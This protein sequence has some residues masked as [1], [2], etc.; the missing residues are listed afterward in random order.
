MQVKVLGPVSAEHAGREISLG[1]RKQRA[2]F[3]LLALQVNRSVPLDRLVHEVWRDEPPAQATLSLQSYISRLRRTILDA[4]GD[5]PTA[6]I[7]RI[8]TRPPGWLLEMAPENID[9]IRFVELVHEGA[10]MLTAGQAE[11]GIANLRGGLAL[12]TGEAFSDLDEMPFAQAEKTRL[13]ELRITATE[14][15]LGGELALGRDAQVV[16]IAREVVAEE[17]YRERA[18]CAWMIALYRQGRQ[19]DALAVAAKLRDTLADGLGLDPSPETR[20]LQEQILRQDPA[21][22]RAPLLSEVQVAAPPLS[23]N[24]GWGGVAESGPGEIIVG[25]DHADTV[26]ADVAAGNDRGRGRLLVVNGPAGIGKSSILAALARRLRHAGLL[27]LEG[28][29]IGAGATPALWPWVSILRQLVAAEPELAGSTRTEGSALALSLLDPS[30]GTGP[31]SDAR[32]GDTDPDLARTRLYRAVVDLLAT[33]HRT[34]PLAV[35]IDDAHWLDADTLELLALAAD[36]LVP[37]GMVVA[38]ALRDDEATAA[39]ATVGAMAARLRSEAVRVPLSGLRPED[40]ELLVQQVAPDADPDER[41][42][43]A[44]ALV[45]RTGGNPLFLSELLRLLHS[46]R[47]LDVSSVE[48][49]LPHQ[50]RDVLRRRL[51]RLPERTQTLLT[52]VALLNRPADVRLLAEVS[53]LTLEGVLDDTEA[54]V[55]TSLLVEDATTRRFTLS[56]DLVRQTLEESLTGLRRARVHA[57]IAEVLRSQE[58]SG[59]TVLPETVVEIAR[60]L[61]LAETVVGASE[62]I[63]YLIRVADDA[64]GHSAFHLSERALRTAVDLCTRIDDPGRRVA[65]QFEL[66]VRFAMQS[67]DVSGATGTPILPTAAEL[68]AMSLHAG[69]DP[70]AWWGAQVVHVRSGMA[71]RALRDAETALTDPLD[72]DVAAMVH[73]IKGLAHFILGDFASADVH[74]ALAEELAVRASADRRE[75]PAPWLSS[76]PSSCGAF[77]S[78]S[79]LLVGDTEAASGH[80]QRATASGHEVPE[81]VF[82]MYMRAWNGAIV[83]D[84]VGALSAALDAE[85][86]GSELEDSYYIAMARI[87]R[88]WAEALLGDSDGVRRTREAY[89]A[90]IAMGMHFQA[91]VHLML[92]AE[93]AASHDHIAEAQDLVRA[94]RAEAEETGERTLGPRLVKLGDDLLSG[95]SL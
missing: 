89:D 77:R 75:R 10:A 20:Q 52:V 28:G 8:V 49:V 43:L 9:A 31:G 38:V 74:L 69:T 14:W 50:V 2:V 60:H 16:E 7:P 53:G 82:V 55:A 36:E 58:Q 48:T 85:E 76:L 6:E 71:A 62:A 63:P 93:A 39:A 40:V 81:R 54:A 11:Q 78:A 19:A 47:R 57:K 66:S 88:G 15:L 83:G 87:V 44:R 59:T 29:G 32:R 64:R 51:D 34:R 73:S 56:H 90:S 13:H 72:S 91:T 37:H 26:L 18:W 30:V 67:M 70:T 35:L 12:W 1:G 24:D 45:A 42:A 22:D 17:P 23:T 92:C 86:L 65:L 41:T 80:L 79:A 25:R 4:H 95:T 5:S 94:A 27:V 33:A 21:L 61:V 3:A 68:R 84:T 46:E